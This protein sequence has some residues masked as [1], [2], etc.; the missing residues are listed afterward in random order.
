M[1]VSADLWDRCLENLKK[2]LNQQSFDTWFKVTTA[3]LHEKTLHVQV[4]N[5]FFRDWIRDHFSPKS[6]K[7]FK[8]FIPNN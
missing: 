8:P 5:E 2:D 1:S 7:P 6:K 4:P 3:S